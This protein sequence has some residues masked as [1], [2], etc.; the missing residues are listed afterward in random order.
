MIYE[1]DFSATIRAHWLN[2][3]SNHHTVCVSEPYGRE[4]DAIN[5]IHLNRL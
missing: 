1:M 2:V 4:N 5:H 3:I